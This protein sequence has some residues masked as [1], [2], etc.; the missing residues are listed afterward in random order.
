[1]PDMTPGEVALWVQA[2]AVVAIA[3]AFWVR[4]K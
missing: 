1:M 2:L 3:L 4:R